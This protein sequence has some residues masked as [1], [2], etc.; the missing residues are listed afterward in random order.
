M[1]RNVMIR[2]KFTLGKY[3]WTIY[4]YYVVTRP[5]AE[6]I[7]ENLIGIGCDGDTLQ[8][9]YGNLTS[10][11]LDTGLTY[12]NKSIGKTVMV[13][14]ATSS[15]KEFQKSYQHETGHLK[16]HIAQA[17][18]IDPHGE[19][20]QYMGDDIV[21]ETWEIAKGLLCEHCRGHAA[22]SHRLY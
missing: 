4:A 13:F 1:G 19:E 10:G 7:L 12:S 21:G 9:A 11:N 16:D 5:D 15:A 3:G 20:L 8:R 6:E 22:N 17:F 14:S 2:Q 18:G